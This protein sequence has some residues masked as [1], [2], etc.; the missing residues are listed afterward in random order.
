MKAVSRDKEEAPGDENTGGP[1]PGIAGLPWE[2]P[3]W[4]YWKPQTVLKFKDKT[5]IK[6]PHQLSQN[7][8]VCAKH[9][10]QPLKVLIKQALHFQLDTK[11][12]QELGTPATNHRYNINFIEQAYINYAAGAYLNRTIDVHT[13]VAIVALLWLFSGWGL[14]FCAKT[15]VQ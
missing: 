10:G 1:H 7:E 2:L 6:S 9:S 3:I 11:F 12:I 4:D 8:E 5:P 15:E 13:D 14:Q